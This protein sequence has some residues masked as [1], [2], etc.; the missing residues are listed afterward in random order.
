MKTARFE[1]AT[2][3]WVQAQL[4]A[5]IEES[6]Q[7]WCVRGGPEPRLTV[8]VCRDYLDQ[9][10]APDDYRFSPHD[11]RMDIARSVLEGLRRR[12]LLG[13]SLAEGEHCS[14]VRCYEPL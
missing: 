4:L 2:R 11:W 3:A 8:T 10:S 13:S 1:K 9:A 14:E 6:Y 5:F 7:A 12:G